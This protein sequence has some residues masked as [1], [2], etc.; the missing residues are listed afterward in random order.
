MRLKLPNVQGLIHPVVP[1]TVRR[2]KGAG[3]LDLLPSTPLMPA[4]SAVIQLPLAYFEIIV[5][6]RM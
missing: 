1:T 4:L 3:G 5:S 2:K 6:A